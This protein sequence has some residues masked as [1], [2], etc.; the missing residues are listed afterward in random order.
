MSFT[1]I[2]ALFALLAFI[3]VFGITYKLKGLKVA[4]LASGIAIYLLGTLFVASIYLRSAAMII[5]FLFR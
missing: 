3:L 1:S 5:W 4:L 2:F